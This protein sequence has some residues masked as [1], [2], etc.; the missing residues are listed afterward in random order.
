MLTVVAC[1]FVLREM[2]TVDFSKLV[3]VP[4]GTTGAVLVIGIVLY[5]LLVFFWR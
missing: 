1:A 5:A 4:A 3:V 2:A